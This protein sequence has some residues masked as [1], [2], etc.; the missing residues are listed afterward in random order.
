MMLLACRNTN[1][2]PMVIPKILP[3]L[4]T[5]T[6]KARAWPAREGGSG[7][8]TGN[9][10]AAYRRPIPIEKGIGLVKNA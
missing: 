3:K 7:A 5:N 10:V 6:R 4:R 8:S 1:F 9:T 2:A